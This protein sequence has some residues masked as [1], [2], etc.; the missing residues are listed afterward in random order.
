MSEKL[1]INP[2]VLIW[3][4]K[5][6]GLTLEELVDNFPKLAFWEQ[7]KIFPTY[8]Q[9]EQLASKYHRPIAVF[10]FPAPPKEESIEKSLR[11]L[12]ENDVQNLSA[13]VRHIFRKAKA[14]QIGL[15]ELQDSDEQKSKISWLSGLSS[16]TDVTKL[17]EIV[18]TKLGIPLEEQFVWESSETALKNWRN[19]LAAN[20]VYAFKEAFK[21][22]RIA[23]FCIY[24]PIYPVVCLNNTDQSAS[25]QIFTLF[26]ELA[27]IIFQ[28]SYLDITS[29]RLWPSSMLDTS[30]LEIRCNLF[31]SQ[32]LVPDS[33]FVSEF[34]NVKEASLTNAMLRSIAN[35]YHVSS[36]VI[37]RRYL[38]KK[39]VSANFYQ[40]KVSEWADATAAAKRA[41]ELEKQNADK[42]SG[43]S[44]DN[45]KMS[46]LGDAYL[47]L[48]LKKYLS[49]SI[50]IEDASNYLDIPPKAFNRIQ[51]TFLQRK[52]SV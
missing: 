37:L 50:G 17:A 29:N 5:A 20:G 43:G 34:L 1:P 13:T 28:D 39:I 26:H 33:H 4:R 8:N 52:D 41:K 31:A 6:Q 49:G 32:F 15:R 23:G 2:E 30:N 44:Y 51:D 10:F 47:S 48:V 35:N 40:T 27:H 25:R 18:R 42:K 22:I 9:L 19:A 11:S 24:D 45:T 38:D 7:G 21:T 3:A 14:F 36:E 16:V 12:S 46:Y